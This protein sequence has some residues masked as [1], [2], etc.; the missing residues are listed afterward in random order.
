MKAIHLDQNYR[1]EMDA[2][3]FSLKYENKYL[4]KD[5]DGKEKQVV[6]KD[7]WHFPTLSGALGKYANESVKVS[8]SVGELIIKVANLETLIQSIK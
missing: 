6:Q 7:E 1:I 4:G 8:E 5:K 3:N 2:Y